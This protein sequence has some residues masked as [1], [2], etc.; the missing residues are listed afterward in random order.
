MNYNQNKIG[1]IN[2]DGTN[3]IS[4]FILGASGPYGVAVDRNYIYW[5]NHTTSTIGRANISGDPS[6]VN[7]SFI[8]G[9]ASPTGVAVDRAHVYYANSPPT[10]SGAPTSTA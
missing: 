7:Q 10:R 9:A 8:T 5:T 6:S 3:N 4:N 1:R 2:S